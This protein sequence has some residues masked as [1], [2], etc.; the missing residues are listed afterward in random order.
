MSKKKT[1]YIFDQKSLSFKIKKSTLKEKLKHIS[2]SVGFGLVVAVLFIVIIYYFID[3]PKEKMLKRQVQTYERQ[4]SVLNKKVDNLSKVLN[5]IEDRDKDVYR[6]VFEAEPMQ[7]NSKNLNNNLKESVAINAGV[8]ND[9]LID[10]AVKKIDELSK[11]LYI[12]S[13]SLDEVFSIAK[14]KKERMVCMP[15]IL[16]I[17]KKASNLISGYGSRFHPILQIR[18]MHSGIDFSAQ[19]GTPIYATGDGVVV[20]SESAGSGYGL[21]VK[22]NHGFGFETLYAHLSKIK[23]KIGQKV[24]RG[25][26]IGLVGSTGLTQAPHLHYEVYKNGSTVNPVYYFFNDLTVEEYEE[27]IEKSQQDNQSLS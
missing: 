4:Y 6:V 22:I 16:P 13:K 11:R 18:R 14:T 5:V 25:D 27:V 7:Y 24:K 10:N 9:E 17:S 20:E 19:T 26:V 1:K 8:N 15:A 2:F 3:S 21:A 23:V 12:Q